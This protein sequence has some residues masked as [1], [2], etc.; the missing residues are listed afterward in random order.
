MKRHDRSGE[1]PSGE[2]DQPAF[3]TRPNFRRKIGAERG[4]ES[5]RRRADGGGQTGDGRRL[6]QSGHRQV[7]AQAVG[8]LLN[9][10]NRHE[11]AAAEV[12]EVVVQ[13]DWRDA[14]GALP[15]L[16]HQILLGCVSPDTYQ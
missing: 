11:R 3:P 13:A 2:V 7:Q 9:H 16:P 4:S 14:Q 1:E 12:E 8:N 6:K 10:L 5:A 15:H